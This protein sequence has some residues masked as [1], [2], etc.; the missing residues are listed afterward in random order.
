MTIVTGLVRY[1][2]RYIADLFSVVV[3]EVQLVGRGLTVVPLRLLLVE[4]QREDHIADLMCRGEETDLYWFHV[5]YAPIG[6]VF[7]RVIPQK[8]VINDWKYHLQK[9][10]SAMNEVQPISSS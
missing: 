6:L 3:R 1:N 9:T 8:M 4:V 7:S 5:V 10:N 2:L